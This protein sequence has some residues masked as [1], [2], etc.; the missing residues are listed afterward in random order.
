M[1]HGLQMK[2]KLISFGKNVQK[3]GFCHFHCVKQKSVAILR[4]FQLVSLIQ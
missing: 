3:L 4:D 1:I 2:G